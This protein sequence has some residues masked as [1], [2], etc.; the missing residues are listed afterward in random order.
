MREYIINNPEW[1]ALLGVSYASVLILLV[2]CCKAWYDLK[3]DKA[4]AKRYR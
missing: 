4:I 3:K 2:V 1:A